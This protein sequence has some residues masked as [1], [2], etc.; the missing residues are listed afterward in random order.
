MNSQ[1]W[2]SE[3]TNITDLSIPLIPARIRWVELVRWQEGLGNSGGLLEAGDTVNME[4]HER[5][6]PAVQG[7]G[8][9]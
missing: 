1:Y 2:L 8:H 7:W 5:E 6:C 4:Q 9:W 3:V